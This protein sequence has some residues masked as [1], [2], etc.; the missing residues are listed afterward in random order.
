LDRQEDGAGSDATLLPSARAPPRRRIWPVI[1]TSLILAGGAAWWWESRTAGQPERPTAERATVVRLGEV[2]RGDMPVTL[3]GLGTVTSLSTVVVKT[4]ISGKITEI[5]FEEGQSVKKGDFLAQIDP[6]PFQAALDQAKG[7]L[8][9]DQAMLAEA[10]IDL[11]RFEKLMTQDSIARQQVDT[12]RALVLQDEAI[13]RSDEANVESA[14]IN[15]N[16]CHIVSPN[17][18]RVG[19]RLVDAGNYVT[20]GDASGIAVIAQMQ[21]ISVIFTLPQDDIPQFIKKL[22]SG[23]TLPVLAYDR[24]GNTQL[25]T[26]KLEAIDSQIDTTTGTVKLRASFPNEDETL[27]PNQFV[28]ARLVVDTLHDATLVPSAGV[29]IGAPGPY[30]Y[31]ANKDETVSVRPIEL[32]P[33]DAKQVAVLKGLSPGD[34]V[35]VD[36]LDH[37]RDGAKIKATEPESP[38]PSAGAAKGGKSAA[39]DKAEPPQGGGK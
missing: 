39:A 24:S 1:V 11:A 9:R 3:E 15:L 31:I 14:Q 2:T 36:G 23:V 16:W 12:Q 32:G 38:A 8:A 28:N 7:A 19:L 33:S 4:Q 25:A 18:G 21:P 22:R 5:G 20:P 26:G 35:V 34:K 6:Q 17:E 30:V 10:R 13:I 37:L 29:Q 27:F